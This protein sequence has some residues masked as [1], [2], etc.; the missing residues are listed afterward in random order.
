MHFATFS[1]QT[2]RGFEMARGEKSFC[3]NHDDIKPRISALLATRRHS[4]SWTC[5]TRGRPLRADQFTRYC[6]AENARGASLVRYVCTYIR[7]KHMFRIRAHSNAIVDRLSGAQRAPLLNTIFYR[8]P[9]CSTT[10]PHSTLHSSRYLRW[11]TRD[12]EHCRS[13]DDIE[14]SP[15]IALNCAPIE[16]RVLHVAVATNSRVMAALSGL[17]CFDMKQ[18]EYIE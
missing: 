15:R 9:F 3:G 10:R 11:R 12:A 14:S 5:W 16:P 7:N 18:E 17:Q 1:R 2:T 6:S 13:T 4:P 8:G